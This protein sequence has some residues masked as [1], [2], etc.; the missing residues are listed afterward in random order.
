MMRGG[1]WVLSAAIAFGVVG[2]MLVV[3][4]AHAATKTGTVVK[5]LDGDSVEVRVAGR[6]R[7]YHLKGVN[8]PELKGSSSK[9]CYGRAAQRRLKKFLKK[10]KRVG[11]KTRGRSS[12]AEI[13]RGRTDVNRAMV[14]LGYARAK[15]GNGSI[16]RRLRK[17]QSSAKK[18][19][20]GL[21]KSCA[22]KDQGGGTPDGQATP[23]AQAG[24]VTGQQAIDRMTAELRDAAFRNFQNASESSDEFQLHLCGDGRFRYYHNVTFSS[25]EFSSVTITERFGNPWTVVEALIRADGSYRGAVVRGTYTSKRV[26]DGGSDSTQPVNEPA[27]VAL[28]NQNGQWFWAKKAAQHFPGQAS[29][30]PG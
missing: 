2:A 28:E 24:D 27:E 6:T 7:T 5:V 13:R 11:V 3:A 21:W 20:R 15:T 17:D 23:N 10:G 22:R 18:R 9:R 25:P 1:S 16:G 29:C 26:R 30:D 12:H 14:R 19:N 4:P 8:A